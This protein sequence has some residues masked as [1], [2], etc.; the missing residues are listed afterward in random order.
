MSV[1][2]TAPAS[3]S[4][5]ISDGLS[6]VSL[7]PSLH[8]KAHPVATPRRALSQS[9]GRK[10]RHGGSGRIEADGVRVIV[11]ASVSWARGN[12]RRRESRLNGD[13]SG[14]LETQNYP[15]DKK[16]DLN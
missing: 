8:I 16:L 7:Y 10:W 15:C 12:Q 4:L 13:H 9:R 14:N 6:P 2:A 1:F 3:P 11:S 5:L